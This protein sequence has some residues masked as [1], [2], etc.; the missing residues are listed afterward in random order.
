MDILSDRFQIS[1]TN[2]ILILDIKVVEFLSAVVDTI[3]DIDIRLPGT[4]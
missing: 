2:L 1:A 3:E 4:Q